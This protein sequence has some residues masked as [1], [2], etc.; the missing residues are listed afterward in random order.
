MI[1]QEH[2]CGGGATIKM[3]DTQIL[4]PDSANIPGSSISCIVKQQ[5]QL[6][7]RVFTHQQLLEFVDQLVHEHGDTPEDFQQIHLASVDATMTP[8]HLD[9]ILGSSP[10]ALSHFLP[11]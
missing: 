8:M 11:R 9:T 6:V 3:C 10:G 4:V 7:Q 2:T 5:G 1:F